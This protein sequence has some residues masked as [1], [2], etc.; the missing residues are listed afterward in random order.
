MQVPPSLKAR[1]I[2]DKVFRAE[3]RVV[4]VDTLTMWRKGH[5]IDQPDMIGDAALCRSGPVAAETSA[6]QRRATPIDSRSDDQTSRPGTTGEA[7]VQD[8]NPQRPEHLVS[9]PSAPTWLERQLASFGPKNIDARELGADK[10]VAYLTGLAVHIREQHLDDPEAAWCRAVNTIMDQDGV[11][12][13]LVELVCHEAWTLSASKRLFIELDLEPARTSV[14]T[15]IDAYY[16]QTIDKTERPAARN[17]NIRGRENVVVPAAVKSIYEELVRW[18][19]QRGLPYHAVGVSLRKLAEQ[20]DWTRPEGS[21]RVPDQGR[22][23]RAVQ[24]AV[25]AQ[26]M[27]RLDR[28]RPGEGNALTALYGLRGS[29]ETLEYVEQHGRQQFP[30]RA[31]HGVAPQV[32]ELPPVADEVHFVADEVDAPAAQPTLRLVVSNNRIRDLVAEREALTG[33]KLVPARTLRSTTITN[34]R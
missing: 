6:G 1:R 13:D 5:R 30:Y 31:R 19:R 12:P 17:S 14:R 7:R 22:A 20:L 3:A 26:V 2:I 15:T 18:A 32:V 29:G 10:T 28:G 23:A 9:T 34:S 8:P 25:D 16:I 21:V 24:A 11:D 4:L 33:I 27:V